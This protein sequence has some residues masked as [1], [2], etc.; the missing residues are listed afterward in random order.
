MCQVCFESSTHFGHPKWYEKRFN[1]QQDI[2][3]RLFCLGS[4]CLY[5]ISSTMTEESPFMM[6]SE[7]PEQETLRSDNS[8]AEGRLENQED[9]N[10]PG[11][12]YNSCV[13]IL[14]Y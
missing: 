4:R 13:G 5:N 7:E 14:N 9:E 3:L 6:T 2:Y 11:F 1:C 8:S 10:V 12:V